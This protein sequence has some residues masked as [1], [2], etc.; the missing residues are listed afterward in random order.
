MSVHVMKQLQRM[1]VSLEAAW[2][3]FSHPKN[4]AAITP[5]HL[6]LKFTNELFRE[7]AYAG[8]VI[9]Y[10]VRP[11]L[12]IP[13]FWMTEITHVQKPHFFVDEQRKGP[14]ALWHHEHHFR[15]VEGGVEMTDI[16]HYALPFG[17]LG[18]LGLPLVKKQLNELF[19]YRREKI[20]QL[21]G[22]LV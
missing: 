14:Y 15:E 5:P 8:Q 3:F 21:W 20:T 22:A 19:A 1:P 9:T 16:I 11:L 2:E 4:L 7:E 18:S 13:L 12:G 10:K 17:P 6:N